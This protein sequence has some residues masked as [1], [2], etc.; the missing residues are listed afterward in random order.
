LALARHFRAHHQIVDRPTLLA[1]GFGPDHGARQV[2]SGR[3]QRVHRGVYCAYTGPLSFLSR[4]EAALRAA[5]HGAVL[6]GAAALQLNERRWSDFSGPIEV[7]VRHGATRRRL[8][9]VR[10]R[11][12]NAMTSRSWWTRQSMPVLRPEWAAITVARRHPARARAT[13]SAVVQCGHVLPGHLL[14]VLLAIGS[15]RGRPRLLSIVADIDGGSRSELEAIFLELCRRAGVVPPQ[16]N[17]PLQLGDRRAWLDACWP[18]LWIAVEIDGKSYHV[19]SEDWERD[20]DRQNDLVLDGWRVLRITAA[21]LR[22]QPEVVVA[23][24]RRAVSQEINR[25]SA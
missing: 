21:M 18:D 8:P 15:F 12:T 1:L 6:D 13:L 2:D 22:E 14:A 17:F 10:I 19:L 11:Q 23:R 5:G 7:V 24:L 25:A 4:C 3:W 16:R 9:G 20:L